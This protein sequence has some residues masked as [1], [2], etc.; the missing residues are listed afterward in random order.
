MATQTLSAQQAQ[1]DVARRWPEIQRL[2]Q[3]SG[4]TGLLKLAE[5]DKAAKALGIRSTP[6][7]RS[8]NRLGRWRRR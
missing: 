4:K 6:T 7:A 5:Y 2:V 1:A 3:Q 8:R